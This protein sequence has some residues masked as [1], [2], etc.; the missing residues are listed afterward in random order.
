[1]NTA[2]ISPPKITDS[3]LQIPLT[4]FKWNIHATQYSL[5]LWVQWI[6]GTKV[7]VVHKDV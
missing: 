2:R 6:T 5:S 1:M 4:D 7:L 3:L